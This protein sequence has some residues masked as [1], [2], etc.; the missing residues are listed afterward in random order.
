MT[1]FSL[2]ICWLLVNWLT[3][4]L[5]TESY[6]ILW[7]FRFFQTRGYLAKTALFSY[8]GDVYVFAEML[9]PTMGTKKVDFLPSS[10]QIETEKNVHATWTHF[11]ITVRVDDATSFWWC[12]AVIIDSSPASLPNS[13]LSTVTLWRCLKKQ[14]YYIG[15]TI[16]CPALCSQFTLTNFY[17]VGKLNWI[18]I[19]YCVAANRFDYNNR[20]YAELTENQ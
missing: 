19:Y 2:S 1:Q 18:H 4:D 14:N 6:Q 8:I 5:S 13:F 9:L 17:N 16:L 7:Y 15:H 12:L 11:V 20:K 3:L 10:A